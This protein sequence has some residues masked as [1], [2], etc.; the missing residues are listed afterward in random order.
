MC[1]TAVDALQ[2]IDRTM[3]EAEVTI[4]LNLLFWRAR[5]KRFQL[6]RYK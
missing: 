6:A 2:K 1:G 4:R 5:G 3:V